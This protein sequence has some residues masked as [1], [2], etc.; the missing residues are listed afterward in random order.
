MI[1]EP[2]IY[3]VDV[4]PLLPVRPEPVKGN[5]ILGFRTAHVVHAL[6]RQSESLRNAA[7]IEPR[8]RWPITGLNQAAELLDELGQF[9]GH[10]PAILRSCVARASTRPRPQKLSPPSARTPRG[11]HVSAG[12]PAATPPALPPAHKPA[13][14]SRRRRQPRPER[15]QCAGDCGARMGI[16]LC[17]RE[18][19]TA[20][21]GPPR[22]PPRLGGRARPE[23]ARAGSAGGWQGAGR[24]R[25]GR[26]PRPGRMSVP[27]GLRRRHRRQGPAAAHSRPTTRRT[28]RTEPIEPAPT[29]D[30]AYSLPSLLPIPRPP[31]PRL[32]PRRTDVDPPVS[33]Q[34]PTHPSRPPCPLPPPRPRPPA[35]AWAN[36]H[37]MALARGGRGASPRRRTPFLESPCGKRKTTVGGAAARSRL[38]RTPGNE[39]QETNTKRRTGS[40]RRAIAFTRGCRIN[41]RRARWIRCKGG[42]RKRPPPLSRADRSARCRRVQPLW[43]PLPRACSGDFETALCDSLTR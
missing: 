13:A 20:E 25:G 18:A 23:G 33:N 11:A 30:P 22:A 38:R 31:Y 29:P 12:S 35:P 8:R 28:D 21:N 32:T 17:I 27:R 10:R 4:K 24:H 43:H 41:A 16:R 42:V 9:A 1:A 34:T 3:L 5:R 6:D 36:P 7:G 15:R 2:F 14:R 26:Q 37:P 19:R 39:H 40:R